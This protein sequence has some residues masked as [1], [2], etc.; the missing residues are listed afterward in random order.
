MTSPAGKLRQ[1]EGEDDRHPLKTLACTGSGG[2]GFSFCWKNMVTP[3][4]SG[5]APM[6]SS[7][8]SGGGIAG[9]QPEQVEQVGRVG[10]RKIVDPAEERR[11]AH[12]DGDEEHLVEREEHRDLDDDGQA[13]AAGLTFSD[14]YSAIIACCMLGVVV[15]VALA[16]RRHLR[17][18]RLHPAHR[19]GRTCWP[20]GRTPPSRTPS[21]PGSPGR[22]CRTSR[23]TASRARR[24]TAWS[25]NRTSRS[26][27]R[28][29]KSGMP[30]CPA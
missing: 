2:C 20:A 23:G 18:Q 13:A 15:L 25:G 5:Q 3:M 17:A 27:S 7:G 19:A 8:R 10:R 9:D 24:R 28:R 11:V 29:S 4:I 22:N 6:C 30:S 12:L 1:H 21:T 14:L 16:Q 26:R